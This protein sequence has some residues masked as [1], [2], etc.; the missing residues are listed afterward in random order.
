MKSEQ[1]EPASIAAASRNDYGEALQQLLEVQP[2]CHACFRSIRPLVDPS[3]GKS[4]VIYA[5]GEFKNHLIKCK[6]FHQ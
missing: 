1:V 5:I 4:N 2:L 3:A 6:W